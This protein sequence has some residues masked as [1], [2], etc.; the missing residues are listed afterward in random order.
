MGKLFAASAITIGVLGS[1]VFCIITLALLVTDTFALPV[2][3]VAT[4][5]VNTLLFFISPFFTDLMQRWLYKTTFLKEEEVRQ[6]YPHMYECVK[7]VCDEYHFSFPR[8]G[9]IEDG[10]PTAFTYG[11][12]RYN[13]RIIVT[14][15][16]FAFLDTEEVNAVIA[17]ELGHIVH[18][19]FMVM[20][21]AS[22]LLQILYEMYAVFIRVKGKKTGPIK[23]LGLLS[24]VLYVIG[25]YMILYLSRTREYLADRFSARYTSP[26]TLANALIKIAYGIVAVADED[27]Q[28]R[29]LLES[30]RQLGIVDVKNAK[31]LGLVSFNSNRDPRILAEV[32]VFDKVNPWAQIIELSSTHPLTGKRIDALARLAKEKNLTFYCDVEAAIQRMSIDYGR[33]YNQF[34]I[35]IAISSVPYITV[36]IGLF[37]G[38]P[39]HA[40]LGF[41]LG[42]IIPILYKFPY[43][44]KVSTTI[45]DEMRNPY[46]SPMR[47]KVVALS[48]QVIGKGIPG[49]VFSEDMM[50][51]D[52][53]GLIFLDYTSLFGF[54]G[55]FFFALG[56]MKEVMGK[57][58]TATGWFTRT[59]SSKIAL[60]R[61]TI[62]SEIIT[63]H[64]VVWEIVKIV[65]LIGLWAF[66]FFGEVF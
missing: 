15:G 41:G 28:S 36:L 53:T 12:G 56:K 43:S 18:R 33:L 27:P 32:L 4:I 5:I 61:M 7:K 64:P 51:Q 38:N 60:Q 55:N 47:G 54:L 25:T 23:V 48:G 46:A 17:H 45:L 59:M 10:N 31:H 57:P 34:F 6:Q 52:K 50:Y 26:V 44:D 8:F 66:L 3:I 49:Y 63:S 65:L 29:R 16:L 24:Y 62:E 13:A 30:T 39:V 11:S 19:D 14:R 1:F 9:F 42:L 2:A 58:S 40:I 37:S 20:M 22:T 21:V 35:E